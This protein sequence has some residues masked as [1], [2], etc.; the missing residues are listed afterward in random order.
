M[1]HILVFPTEL[2]AKL[3]E[4]SAETAILSKWNVIDIKTVDEMMDR[5]VYD[6]N[7]SYGLSITSYREE[8]SAEIKRRID[9]SGNV[10]MFVGYFEN[11]SGNVDALFFY[12]PP[13]ADNANDFLPAKVMP[14][15]FGIYNNVRERTKDK[16]IQCMPVFIVNLCITSRINNASVK[17]QIICCETLGFYYYDV[18]QNEY[19]DVIGRTDTDGN[20]ITRINK[21]RELDDLLGS[22]TDNKWFEVDYE[23]KIM[24][25]LNKTIVNSTNATSDIYRLS[26]Y[27]IPAVYM[28][29]NEGYEIDQ[30]NIAT[31]NGVVAE[32]LKT[33]ISKIK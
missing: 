30:S 12:I 33:F 5:I 24:R 16:H 7:I 27:V 6:L 11:E 32:T 3:N 9:S 19:Y 23:N 25:I 1:N 13:K 26:L 21:L 15:L 18:F 28:A 22:T 2:R 14:P 20:F 10:S 8:S 31:L 17:K 29:A 4:V